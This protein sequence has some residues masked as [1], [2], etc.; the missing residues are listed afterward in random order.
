MTAELQHNVSNLKAVP[1][2][3]FKLMISFCFLSDLHFQFVSAKLKKSVPRL[4]CIDLCFP[5]PV[6]GVWDYREPPLPQAQPHDQTH[7]CEFL[8]IFKQQNCNASFRLGCIEPFLSF[9]FSSFQLVFMNLW[10]TSSVARYS[11]FFFL[12]SYTQ[13]ILPCRDEPVSPKGLNKV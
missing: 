11:S 2:L 4:V 9:L 3:S 10:L 7:R 13:H 12:T 8:S 5:L 1:L 6:S